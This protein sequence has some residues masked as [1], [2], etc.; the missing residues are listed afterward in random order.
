MAERTNAAGSRPALPSGK[1]GFKSL[2]RRRFYILIDES[3]NMVTDKQEFINIAK[4]FHPEASLED[5]EKSYISYCELEKKQE[6]EL[7]KS[8]HLASGTE[9]IIFKPWSD[10]DVVEVHAKSPHPLKSVKLGF[11]YKGD[12]PCDSKY[13]EGSTVSTNITSE[14][15][16]KGGISIGII[17]L[18]EAIKK[19]KNID[20]SKV[21]IER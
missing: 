12:I 18:D 3:E 7:K 16:K 17:S 8:R 2:P 15:S 20:W 19:V 6:E 11:M 9:T 13:V 21:P 1:L 4:K 14:A 5:I 10:F